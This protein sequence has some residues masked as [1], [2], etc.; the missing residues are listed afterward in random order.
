MEIFQRPSK[1]GQ[2]VLGDADK[3]LD[4]SLTSSELSDQWPWKSSHSGT[5]LL[6]ILL[7]CSG[8][9]CLWAGV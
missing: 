7:L 1:Y 9:Q 3:D 2:L 8:I 6:F 4:E 5:L